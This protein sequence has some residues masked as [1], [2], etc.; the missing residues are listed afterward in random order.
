M[1]KTAKFLVVAAI[2]AFA[3]SSSLMAQF[4]IGAKAGVAMNGMFGKDNYYDKYET[5]PVC[6]FRAGVVGEYILNNKLSV[7]AELLYARQG[8][9][10]HIEK[11]ETDF[12]WNDLFYKLDED[13]FSNHLNI[14]IMLQYN[15]GGFYVEAG[16]QVGFCL[17]GKSN[18]SGEYT[19]T[20]VDED[21]FLT[22]KQS[23]FDYENTFKEIE[24][25]GK[26]RLDDYRMYNRVNV[27]FAVG[28]GYEFPFG[29]FLSARYAMD[30]TNSYNK[31]TN[32]ATGKAVS[33]ES[34]PSKQWGAVLAVGYKFR[35]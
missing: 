31:I 2:L 29:V 6:G 10:L 14:P 4:K 16:P 11:T 1:K 9:S 13:I 5:R 25:N 21:Y 8:Y 23:T 20:G 35:I 7:S 22:T 28:V 32:D 12:A 17:G 30:F 19:Y 26:E 15:F 34:F 33:W 3:T 27:G 18:S 24:S